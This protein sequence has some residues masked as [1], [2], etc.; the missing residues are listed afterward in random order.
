[1]ALPSHFKPWKITFDG[2]I[3]KSYKKEHIRD[4]R[5]QLIINSQLEDLNLYKKAYMI[6]A[7]DAGL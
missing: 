2:K 7:D 1:M 4:K 6:T 3:I 5:F